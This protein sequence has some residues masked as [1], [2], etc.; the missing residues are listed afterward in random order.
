MNRNN[1]P[2][3]NVFQAFTR[4]WKNSL[5][6]WAADLLRWGVNM[7]CRRATMAEKQARPVIRIT[8][9]RYAAAIS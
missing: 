8:L 9:E 4:A 2:R 1:G 7:S 5:F 6:G 3:G